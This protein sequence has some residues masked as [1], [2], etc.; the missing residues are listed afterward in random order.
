MWLSVM[1][2]NCMESIRRMNWKRL[3]KF[4]SVGKNGGKSARTHLISVLPHV[5]DT[6]VIQDHLRLPLRLVGAH[7]SEITAGTVP[8]TVSVRKRFMIQVQAWYFIFRTSFFWFC[9]KY[10]RH[11]ILKTLSEIP[12]CAEKTLHTSLICFI[13]LSKIPSLSQIGFSA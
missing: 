12:L 4:L 1:W 2:K 8:P 10:F 6:A 7:V 11:R 3:K 9:L 5:S 13:S